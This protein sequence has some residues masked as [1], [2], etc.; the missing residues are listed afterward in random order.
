MVGLRWPEEYHHQG[1]AF[2]ARVQQAELGRMAEV[3]TASHFSDDERSLAADSWSVKSEYGSVLDLE[4]Q[5]QTDCEGL[6]VSSFRTIDYSYDKD[7]EDEFEPSTLGLQSHWDAAYAEEL[8]N[9]H[10]HGDAGEIWFG[11]GVMETM[12]SWTA[13]ICTS[14][15]AGLCADNLDGFS[16]LSISDLNIFS[17]ARMVTELASWNVLDIGT[18]NGVL[19]HTLAKQGFSNLT[20]TDYSEGAIELAKAVAERNNFRDIK[21]LVDDILETKLHSQFKLITDKGTLDAIGLHPEGVQRR[22][23]YWKA[24]SKLISPGGVLVITSC[25]STKDELVEEAS[26]YM[27]SPTFGTF[28]LRGEDAV[29]TSSASSSSS[30]I[31]PVFHYIDHIKTYPTFRFGGIEGTRVCT[32]AF[33]RTSA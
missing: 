3:D 11:E 16:L 25:N 6:G 19:L 8:A 26:S 13:K 33:L 14:V 22:V 17:E 30:D 21:F 10:E 32:V 18:G 5:R 23:M 31:Q 24:V 1:A 2:T 4:D 9:F 15:A 20:G 29:S 12:G 28:Y 7:D 27:Q